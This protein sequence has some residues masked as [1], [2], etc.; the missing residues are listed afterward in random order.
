MLLLLARS[1]TS[2]PDFLSI[3]LHFHL[4]PL[5]S[6]GLCLNAIL[7]LLT[8]P[9]SSLSACLRFSSRRQPS[10]LSP[11]LLLSLVSPQS[12]PTPPVSVS[13]TSKKHS[14]PHSHDPRF[15]R[16]RRRQ[17]TPSPST[18][19]RPAR[20]LTFR[21]DRALTVKVWFCDASEFQLNSY[22]AAGVLLRF[23]LFL[24]R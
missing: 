6:P 16:P 3:F 18:H 19:K 17:Q 23:D 22:L 10:S 20:S 13:S 14:S 11:C 21:P 4:L 12:H 2:T 7:R 1:L 5:H 24:N 8:T 15:R 9:I